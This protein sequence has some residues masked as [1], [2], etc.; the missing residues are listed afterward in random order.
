M[1]LCT[2]IR[3]NNRFLHLL[4]SL[5]ISLSAFAR[6]SVTYY[7]K[8]SLKYCVREDSSSVMVS[9]MAV[10]DSVRLPVTKDGT[11]VIPAS[12]SIEGHTYNVEGIEGDGFCLHPE[13]KHLVLN[14]GINYVGEYAFVQ[15]VNL[16]SIHFPS[17]VDWIGI[18]AFKDCGMLTS[19]TVEDGNDTFDSRSNCNAVIDTDDDKLILGCR[20]T[21]IPEG[22]VTIGTGAFDGQ[23]KLDRIILPNSIKEIGNYAFI[24]C[25][26]L[27]H[28]TLPD[29]L[30]TILNQAFAGCTSLEELFIPASVSEIE[31]RIVAGCPRLKRIVVSPENRTY[32][33]RNHCNAIIRTKDD[34]LVAG[35][36]ST[37][38]VDGIRSIAKQAFYYS[39]ITHINIPASVTQIDEDAFSGCRFCIAIDVA[40]GNPVYDSRKECNAIIETA[41]GTLVK[42][43]GMTTFP[44]G[45]SKIGKYAFYGMTMP[46][47]YI[48]PEGITA[49]MD[50]AFSCCNFYSVVLPKSLRDIKFYAFANCMQLTRIEM[51]STDLH[52]GW[53]AFNHCYS[54]CAVRLPQNVTFERAD[55]FD[56]TPYK[57]VYERE[58]GKR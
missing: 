34:C 39:N 11:L 42:G 49:I 53:C 2:M 56:Y 1:E 52:I 32:D 41:T 17:T 7:I 4:L 10:A 19:I 40:P 29:S 23:Q 18:S 15:C 50:E 46:A 43:C 6:Q 57:E 47:N 36:S 26:G 20:S 54:L 45:V 30:E 33:S 25:T 21:Q 28:V 48:I 3:T 8:D 35:C 13:I 55:A 38:I 44:S 24:N 12:F 27:K 9:V 14:E 5:S 37:T 16:E 58:Y 51:N 31:E 22:I